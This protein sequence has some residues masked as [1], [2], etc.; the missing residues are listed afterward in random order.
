MKDYRA[1]E[2]AG[3]DGVDL[4]GRRRGTG[5]Q[6]VDLHL[7]LGGRDHFLAP[8][9]HGLVD[10]MLG[11]GEDVAG[12]SVGCMADTADGGHGCTADQGGKDQVSHRFTPSCLF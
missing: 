7:A 4:L 3:D 6:E 2:S 12:P 9:L 1:I 5:R 11:A 10:E 8:G